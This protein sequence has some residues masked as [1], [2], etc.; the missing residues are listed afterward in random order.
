[1][2]P[3][4]LQLEE[5]FHQIQDR[6]AD[7]SLDQGSADCRKMLREYKRLEVAVR[8]TGDLRK[9]LKEIEG[10]DALRGDAEMH[11]PLSHETDIEGTFG[12]HDG[13]GVQSVQ[14]RQV[15]IQHRH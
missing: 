13:I 4:F 9:V 10:L 15:G 11:N 2:N 1:M 7:P 8:K 3:K 6:L 5:R 14:P 12:R